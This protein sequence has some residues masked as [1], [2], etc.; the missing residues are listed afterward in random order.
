VFRHVTPEIFE[1]EYLFNPQLRAVLPKIKVRAE[2]S[3]E[4]LFP[5]IQPCKVTITTTDGRSVSKRLDWPKG[6]PR[7]PMTDDELNTKVR[8]LTE[9]KLS[10]KAH[11][12][13]RQIVFNLD[14]ISKTEELMRATLCDI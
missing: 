3:F 4:K 8:S 14:Q 13:L 1:K 11:D 5:K 9:P 7:S 12:Q 6:D 2:P 10:Q